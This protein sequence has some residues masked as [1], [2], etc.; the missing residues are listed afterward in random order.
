MTTRQSHCDFHGK[1][2]VRPFLRDSSYREVCHRVLGPIT[3]QPHRRRRYPRS[4][5]YGCRRRMPFVSVAARVRLAVC[6]RIVRI[7]LHSIVQR[8]FVWVASS[9]LFFCR[10]FR[11]LRAILNPLDQFHGFLLRNA[12]LALRWHDIIVILGQQDPLNQQT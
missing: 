6:D 9:F 3:D 1:N 5:R 4:Q 10:C 2:H 8:Q 7:V 11:K 12:A